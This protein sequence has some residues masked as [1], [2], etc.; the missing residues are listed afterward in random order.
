LKQ[1]VGSV[2]QNE[3][4]TEHSEQEG[5]MHREILYMRGPAQAR[6]VSS[7]ANQVRA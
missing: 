4:A 7:P 6:N 1:T 3:Q 5:Q 2:G